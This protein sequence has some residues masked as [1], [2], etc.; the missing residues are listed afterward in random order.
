VVEAIEVV[1]DYPQIP[2]D[3][4]LS[5]SQSQGRQELAW[6]A[7]A[8]GRVVLEGREFTEEAVITSREPADSQPG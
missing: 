7:V 2:F 6:C 1:P 8:D 4:C 3:D 5:V